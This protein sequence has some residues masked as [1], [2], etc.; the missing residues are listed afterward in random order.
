MTVFDFCRVCRCV[1]AQN[2]AGDSALHCAC[3][4]GR[5]E[6][7]RLLLFEGFASRVLRDGDERT[8]REV[9]GVY[10]HKG[11]MR[12]FEVCGGRGLFLYINYI[13]IYIYI[14][15][16]T[17]IHLSVLSVCFVC[18]LC[19]CAVCAC[20]VSLCVCLCG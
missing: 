16:R 3:R 9:A 2:A 13:Y 18:V 7:V 6:I 5:S 15:R 8:A 10:A 4:Y 12:L 14:Y 1:D 17:L 11:V 19:A 20:F